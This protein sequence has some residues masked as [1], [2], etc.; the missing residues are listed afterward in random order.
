M[1][2]IDRKRNDMAFPRLYYPEL[3]LLEGGYK[4]FYEQFPVS[5]SPT[6]CAFIYVCVSEATMYICICIHV[7][8]PPLSAGIV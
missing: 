1:R 7:S 4:A 5:L 3:Y 2:G 8:L 6:V